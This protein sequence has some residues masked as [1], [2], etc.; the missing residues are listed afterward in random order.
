MSVT[1]DF[2][3]GIDWATQAHQ[4]CILDPD[5]GMIDELSVEHSHQGLAGLTGRLSKLC[6]DDLGRAGVAIEV[7]R[8]AVVE[9]LI[10]RGAAV[11]AI[12]PKQLDRFRDRHTVAGAK[13]DRRDALV[14]ADSL[15]TDRHCFRPLRLDDPQVIQLRELSRI[16]E[17]LCVALGRL[18]SRLREQLHRYAPHLLTLCPA[19]D[20]P[21]LWSLLELAANPERA[22]RLT[23]AQ[24]AKVLKAHRIRRFSAAEVLKVLRTPPLRVAPGTVE[25]ASDHVRLLI[26]QLCLVRRQ[27]R[28]GQER[29]EAWLEQLADG[30]E[31]ASGQKEKHRD[32]EI[33]RSIPGIGVLVAATMLAEGGQSLAE[34]NYPALRAQTG[35][36]P[37]TRPSGKSCYVV[38]RRAC[39][40]RLR[41]AL[42]HWARV[43]VQHDP[44][45]RFRYHALR[46]KGHSH[47]R[48]L[49]GVADRLLSMLIAMLETGT[50]Y[51]PELQ[52]RVPAG[53][54]NG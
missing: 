27:R 37:V 49:R 43:C 11:Y 20:E 8:G 54:M 35:I 53:V 7:P 25:A 38:M 23:K 52:R 41:N 40:V 19:A 29:I 46:Q 10:E 16:D 51:N 33:L 30:E 2:Y 4:V 3:V 34:R 6:G 44:R 42:Y 39:N 21:W 18:A 14:L 1:Y 13:D 15:R 50:L 12:N 24:I 26:E 45:S 17:E 5:G 36:A 32:A 9:T 22:R 48:A 47:G 31:D 28:E